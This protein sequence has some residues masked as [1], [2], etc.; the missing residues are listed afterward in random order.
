MRFAWN[1]GGLMRSDEVRA[2]LPDEVRPTF[3][4]IVDQSILG[5][6][7]HISL[8]GEMIEA[9]ARAGVEAG[10]PSVDIV[11]DVKKVARFFIATR[12]AASQAVSNAVLIMIRGIDT[13]AHLDPFDA[14]A[15]IVAAKDAYAAQA[16]DAIAACVG[17]AAEL[18]RPM[19]RIFVYDYS[20]TVEKFLRAI[21]SD[22][23]REVVIPESRIIDGGKPFVRVCQESGHAVTFIPEA[24]MMCFLRDCDA[25]FMGAETFFPDGT[26][27]NTTGSDIVGVLCGHLG[28]PLYFL[29][30]LIKLDSRPVY[31]GHKRLVYDD[32]TEKL[33][34]DWGE[35][36]AREGIDFTVPEL[37]GVPAGQIRAFVTERGVIPAAQMFGPA[38]EYSAYLHERVDFGAQAPNVDRVDSSDRAKG[39][40]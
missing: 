2:L 5:A 17:Y 22:G 8:I 12:G 28:V 29:T 20:S 25:A 35:G 19:K 38:M 10:K 23:A 3:D 32:L 1:G 6:S 11:R 27:F 37:V 4:G 14:A 31:G 30:P 16:A 40:V 26:G 21:A 15:R 36:L 34:A 9:T 7:R 33:S 39:R 13:C 18:A 24:A